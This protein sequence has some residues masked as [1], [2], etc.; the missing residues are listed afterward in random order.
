MKEEY[1]KRMKHIA[2]IGGKI[3]CELISDIRF[4]LKPD[5]SVITRADIEIS[6]FAH[7]VIADLIK[8]P[9][10]ILIDEE[11]PNNE[12]L[13]QR[14]L[15]RIPYIWVIDPID[16]TRA[17]SNYMPNFG[18]SIGL[19]KELKP[20]LSYVYFP[21]L[22][23]LFF[24]DG[25]HSFF[26]Q[27]AFTINEKKSIIYPIDQQITSQSIFLCND[28][29]YEKF[30]WDFSDCKLMNPSC[31]VLSL[32]W[33]TIGRGCGT[34]FGAHLWDFAGPW[35]IFLSAGLK[36]RSYKTAKEITYLNTELF[37]RKSRDPWKLKEFYIL[38]SEK[39]FSLLRGKI[40]P[41]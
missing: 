1:L 41:K 16:G 26:V 29:F 14:D 27:N 34:F 36:L 35:P 18:I 15:E 39:N 20:W 22:E 37:D 31:A 17:Y 23:E 24:S 11:D 30:N 13:D 9:D 10:H 19:I 6:T 32:C 40:I 5:N 21:K 2:Y 3:A 33:P 8:S 28:S 12:T 38:S 4:Q 7:S 25:E